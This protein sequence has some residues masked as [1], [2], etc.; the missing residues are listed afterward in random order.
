VCAQTVFSWSN[1][2][3]TVLTWWYIILWHRSRV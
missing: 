2:I 3:Y 1:R